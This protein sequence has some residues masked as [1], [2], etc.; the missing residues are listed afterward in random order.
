MIHVVNDNDSLTRC[1]I[2]V[3]STKDNRCRRCC[4][5]LLMG[6][7]PEKVM[8]ASPYAKRFIDVLKKLMR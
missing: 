1:L 2:G 6:I 4:L 3:V 8:S 5:T 7:D